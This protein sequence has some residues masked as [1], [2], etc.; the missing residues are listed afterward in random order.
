MLGIGVC[1]VVDSMEERS[2]SSNRARQK[3]HPND[4]WSLKEFS[5]SLAPNH[6]LSVTMHPNFSY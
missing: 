6:T 1:V 3:M 5:S 4:V 2:T